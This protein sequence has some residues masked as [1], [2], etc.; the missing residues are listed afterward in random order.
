MAKKRRSRRKVTDI[1]AILAD[2]LD[3]LGVVYVREFRIGT[4]SV[5]FY[6]PDCKLS[7]QSDGG[8]W[9]R[10]CSSCPC[11]DESTPKQE[12]QALRDIACI[13]HHKIKKRSIMRFCGCEIKN[14]RDFVA[15]SISK[16]VTSIKLGNL[17]YR[18]RDLKGKET[19]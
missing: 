4:Y 2:I 9:H 7:L 6:V 12:Y 16:A 18:E 3:E 1:E 5:D 15:E 13:V 14:E 8:Y 17:V 19:E 10:Y 11:E